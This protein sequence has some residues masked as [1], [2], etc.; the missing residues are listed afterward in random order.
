MGSEL[1]RADDQTRHA[2]SEGFR[3]WVDILTRQATNEDSKAAR[4]EV[5]FKLSAMI[6]AVTMARIID[7]EKFAD[8]LLT[9]T[10]KRLVNSPSKAPK[11]V[12]ELESV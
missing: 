3:S 2:L 1:A 10:R 12:K 11:K 8:Q 7:D 6:G 5:M 4:G 9:E